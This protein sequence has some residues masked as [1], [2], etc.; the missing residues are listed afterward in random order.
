MRIVSKFKDY[1]DGVQAMGYDPELVYVRESREMEGDFFDSFLLHDNHV[2]DFPDPKRITFW[3]SIIGFCGALYPV[4]KIERNLKTKKENIYRP[5]V[6]YCYSVDAVDEVVKKSTKK[7]YNEY[8]G[9]NKRSSFARKRYAPRMSM[10]SRQNIEAFFSNNF[11]QD[12][13]TAYNA[14]FT[15][16]RIEKHNRQA[17]ELRAGN[18]LKS[19]FFEEKVPAFIVYYNDLERKQKLIL[20]PCLED[21]KFQKVKDPYTAYQEIAQYISGVLGIDSPETVSISDEE[22][23]WEKGFDDWSFKREEHPRKS[24]K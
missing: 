8:Y 6:D 1:Y 17:R 10:F 3:F 14:R 9:E 5:V 12:P 22:M 7:F 20:N 13:D 16:W 4:I 19:L 2:F 21:W 24:K 23:K 11:L 18:Y 15:F